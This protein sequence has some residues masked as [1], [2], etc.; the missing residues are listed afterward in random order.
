MCG[1]AGLLRPRAA[2]DRRGPVDRGLLARMTEAIAHRGPDD[3]GLHC[4]AEIG[5]GFRRL[6][7]IDLVA[8]HQPMA[9]ED[10]SVV[11]VFNGE[12]YNFQALRTELEALG[13]RFATR[14][15]T[16]TI[17]HGWESWGVGCLDRLQGMFAIALWD[18]N[19]R[20]LF[21]ARDR[22]GKK[23]LYYG[24]APDGTLAFGSELAALVPVPG[25]AE[26]ID[27]AAL[28]DFMAYGYVPDPASIYPRIRKLPAAH[29]ALIDADDGE[30]APKR[31]W[32]VKPSGMGSI[33]Q[34]EAVR[35]LRDRLDRAVASRLIADVGLGAF[36]SGGLD[37]GV[38]AALA[39]RRSDERLRCFTIG[40]PGQDDERPAASAV[41]R[42][43]DALH[44][45]EAVTPTAIL[46]AARLQAGLFGEPFADSS[47]VP[48]L[49][50]A[51]LA[52]R[53]VTV[54]LSGDGGDETFGGYRRYRFHRLV[55]SARRFLPPGMRR[56]VIG[57]LAR[58]Y[59]K[60]D[61]APRWLRAKTSLTELSLDSAHGYYR[62]ICRSA[63][64]ARHA[65]YGPAMRRAVGERDPAKPI[66]EIFAEAEDDDPL[67]MAQRADLGTWLAGD[68]LVKVDRTSMAVGLE[69]R[70]PL[71]DH[72]L[73]SWGIGL[74]AQA[75]MERGQ[76]KTVLR[77]LARELLPED[78]VARPKQGFATALGPAL[79]RAGPDLRAR[80]LDGAMTETGLFDRNVVARMID[81]QESGARDHAQSLWQLLVLEGFFAMR[82]GAV[83]AAPALS[84]SSL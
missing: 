73:V 34:D 22:L 59:P 70:C 42:H 77:A 7:I 56:I 4:E 29:Y 17:V 68:M 26:G 80:L 23:P 8:G 52:R 84:E 1:L 6:S 53:H 46:E 83:A 54:A 27:H 9:N 3:Q 64:E 41:A 28:D 44:V 55:E 63:D 76:G 51:S 47:S 69:V 19:R 43:I 78:V 61:R 81:A 21:L 36:L 31:Y 14:T 50:V 13:H 40:F 79:R 49:R 32:S 25:L 71:L 11:L 39:A 37:S 72:D 20:T 24:T 48:S 58:A 15:D 82:A 74:P 38:V 35:A 5:L 65:L 2:I 33:G 57:G 12:I 18:R 10:G 16:E 67:R 75:K 62:T 30:V 66:A 60:L 45:T